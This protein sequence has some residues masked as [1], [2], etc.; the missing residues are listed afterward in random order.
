ML[1]GLDAVTTGFLFFLPNAIYP[2]LIVIGI[3]MFSEL[4]NIDYPNSTTKYATFFIVLGMPMTYFITNGLLLGA[5]V[6][7]LVNIIK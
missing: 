5:L 7:M 4:Q 6:Y 3:M 1:S 2:I